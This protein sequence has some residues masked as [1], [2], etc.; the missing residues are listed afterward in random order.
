MVGWWDGGEIN[1]Q[2]YRLHPS[3]CLCFC[4]AVVESESESAANETTDTVFRLLR[5]RRGFSF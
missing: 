5:V 1:N 2:R 4:E 3:L